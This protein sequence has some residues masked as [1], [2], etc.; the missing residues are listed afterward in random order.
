MTIIRLWWLQNGWQTESKGKQHW[1]VAPSAR[2]C[3]GTECSF[4]SVF[5]LLL[6]FWKKA[7]CLVGLFIIDWLFTYL[8]LFIWLFIYLFIYLGQCGGESCC[9]SELCLQHCNCY[10]VWLGS[11]FLFLSL[12]PKQLKGE[13]VYSTPHSPRAQPIMAGNSRWLMF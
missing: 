7:N 4:S 11:K 3:L 5:Q 10:R 8:Y 2:H 13:R 12:W 9:T 1:R 6:L